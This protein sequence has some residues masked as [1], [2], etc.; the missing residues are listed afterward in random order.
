MLRPYTRHTRNRCQRARSTRNARRQERAH[1]RAGAAP[2]KRGDSRRG[3]TLPAGRGTGDKKRRARLSRGEWGVKRGLRGMK[4]IFCCERQSKTLLMLQES[5]SEG[6]PGRADLEFC[7]TL[8]NGH[9][10]IQSLVLVE[11]RVEINVWS[12]YP[13]RASGDS[14]PPRSCGCRNEEMS[15]NTLNGHRVI[16]R[17]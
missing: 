16:Q 7:N 9:R 8:L 6:R 4:C 17:N 5:I 12:K 1:S 14:E 11:G 13:Q 15:Q 10:V 3:W 2:E